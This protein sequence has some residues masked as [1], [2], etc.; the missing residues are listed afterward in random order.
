MHGICH[1]APTGNLGFGVNSW[2]RIKGR[3]SFDDH[4]GLCNDK[5]RRSS[6][7]VVFRHE[8]AWHMPGFGP[9][10]RERCHEDA[11]GHFESAKLERLEE[12]RVRHAISFCW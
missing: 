12:C 10:T 3:V 7:S 2:L 5:A 8:F 6:L 1:F 4:G 9:A 11:V